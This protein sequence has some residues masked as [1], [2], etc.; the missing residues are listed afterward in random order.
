MLGVFVACVLLGVGASAS[1]PAARTPCNGSVACV[2]LGV[3]AGLL[4]AGFAVPPVVVLGGGAASACG[5][6]ATGAGRG[7]G[8]GVAGCFRGSS[9]AGIE[10]RHLGGSI[11][12]SSYLA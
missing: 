11:Y 10:A 9:A 5:P 2:M 12:T 8:T 6:A 3:A 7:F 1:V 4:C